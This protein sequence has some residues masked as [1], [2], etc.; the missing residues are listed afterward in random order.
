[1]TE[2]LDTV[3][4]VL[5]EALD[6]P[7]RPEDLQE[8]TELFGSLPELDS[9]GVLQLVS[10]IEERFDITIADDEFGAE[11]F[12]TLGSLT[13]FVESKLAAA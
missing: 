3:R 4:T 8:D 1:M 5:I 6:L 2:T 9:L 12:E 11:L 13:A 7:Q 10:A